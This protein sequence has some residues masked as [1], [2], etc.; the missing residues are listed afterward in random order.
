MK[1]SALDSVRRVWWPA[2]LGCLPSVVLISAWKYA[3]PPDS[4]VEIFAV[5]FAAIAVTFVSSWLFSLSG[6]ERKRFLAVLVRT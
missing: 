4:W 2:L 1:I 5:V 3:A 6:L